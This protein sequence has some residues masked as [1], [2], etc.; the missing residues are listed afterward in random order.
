MATEKIIGTLKYSI[1]VFIVLIIC[2]MIKG[3]NYRELGIE[4][5]TFGQGWFTL[6]E[7][8]K[9]QSNFIMSFGK[10]VFFLTL[11]LGEILEVFI[12]MVKLKIKK[13][14]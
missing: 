14:N 12:N 3:F 7:Y 4:Q 6:Y 10:I 2:I 1:I 8:K 11:T 13:E 5:V 9:T